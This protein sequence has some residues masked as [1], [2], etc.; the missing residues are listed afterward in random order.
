MDKKISLAA[1]KNAR[2]AWRIRKEGVVA[3]IAYAQ[4]MRIAAISDHA[5]CHWVDTVNGYRISGRAH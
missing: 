5:R 2:W 4:G 3:P 1:V